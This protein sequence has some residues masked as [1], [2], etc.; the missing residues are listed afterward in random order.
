M[1]EINVLQRMV[2]ATMR[3]T[4]AVVLTHNIDFMFA[5]AILVN[6]LR[7]SGAPRLT[8]FA[9]AGCAAGSFTRQSEIADLVGRSFRVVPVDLG[10]GRRFHPKA[11]F[12]AGPDGARLAVGSGNLGHGGWSGNREIWT[13]FDY[14]G[15][16]GPAIAAFRDYLGEVCELAEASEPVRATVLEPFRSEAW[17]C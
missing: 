13:Y 11:I 6:R 3:A 1:N 9:D 12:L 7:K 4:T 8:V 14:P 5:Q 17:G 10:V 16:G 2:D 15:D